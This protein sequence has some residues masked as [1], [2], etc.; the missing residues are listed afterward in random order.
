[1]TKT[2]SPIEAKLARA[3]DKL[4]R[5]EIRLERAIDAR[6]KAHND[7]L[8]LSARCLDAARGIR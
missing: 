1:M 4:G 3:V 8:V 7:Y 2:D 5:A 6:D